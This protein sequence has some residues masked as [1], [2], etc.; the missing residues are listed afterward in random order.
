MKKWY[1]LFLTISLLSFE[2]SAKQVS[3]NKSSSAGGLTRTLTFS[4]Q[5]VTLNVRHVYN[6]GSALAPLTLLTEGLEKSL[7]SEFSKN[8]IS[9]ITEPIVNGETYFNWTFRCQNGITGEFVM[10]LPSNT[11]GTLMIKAPNGSPIVYYFGTSE[12]KLQ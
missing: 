4:T 12:C 9:S 11:L 7:V 3:C 5:P 1:I 2:I 8:C 10:T 6:D